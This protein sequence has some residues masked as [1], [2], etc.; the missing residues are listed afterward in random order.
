MSEAKQQTTLIPISQSGNLH[1]AFEIQSQIIRIQEMINDLE[2]EKKTYEKIHTTIC[3]D[4]TRARVVRDGDF[5][6]E[7]KETTRR[8]VN[9][10]MV[11][12]LYPD[13]YEEVK[14][15]RESCNLPDLQKYLSGV[16]INKVITSASSTKYLVLFDWRQVPPR[17]E[18]SE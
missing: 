8:T 2:R 11:K 13:I 18:G 15:V 12:K 14:I 5:T 7:L 17:E 9:P 3:E 16:E 6:L 4:Y 10:D 1:D